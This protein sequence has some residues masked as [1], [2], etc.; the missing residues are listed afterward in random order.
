MSETGRST[1][2]GLVGV[3]VKERGGRRQIEIECRLQIAATVV[4]Q[5]VLAVTTNMFK[6]VSALPL[7]RAE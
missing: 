4:G 2:P 6:R 5:C 7:R 1:T 3:K